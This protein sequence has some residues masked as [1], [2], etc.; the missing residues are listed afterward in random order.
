MLQ[1]WHRCRSGGGVTRS[2]HA[3]IVALCEA[4]PALADHLNLRG[5]LIAV[6]EGA[7]VPAPSLVMPAERVRAKLSRGVPL[8]DAEA[9]AIPGSLLTLFHRLAVAWLAD[10]TLGPSVEALLTAARGGG[11]NIEQVLAEA[12]AG[13]ADHLDSLAESVGVSPALLE[14]LA[15]LAVRPLLAG[16]AGRLRP[17]LAL[18]PWE[19]GYCPLC[20]DWPQCAVDEATNVRLLCGRCL[21]S[22][23]WRPPRCPF[24]SDGQM[25]VFASM[26]VVDSGHWSAAGCDSCQHYMKLA[27]AS[28]PDAL[29]DVLLADLETWQLDRAAIKRDLSRPTGPGYRLELLDLDDEA[30][31]E[32]F[33]DG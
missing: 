22:W 12:L 1:T 9:V 32:A 10:P 28:G 5:V 25:T 21:S 7:S 27:D 29:A 17:A 19:R 2:L 6:V 33:D 23:P 20:G 26:T 31:D 13:H 16:L 24:D 3:R 15:D 4:E 14:T 30:A 8:L 11:L 18:G